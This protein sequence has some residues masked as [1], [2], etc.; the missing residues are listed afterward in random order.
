MRKKVG[1]KSVMDIS[2]LCAFFKQLQ[3]VKNN[4]RRERGGATLAN[5]WTMRL[6]MRLLSVDR[7]G[8]GY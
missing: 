7:G 2:L 5:G 3:P 6:A 4:C 1:K 8:R